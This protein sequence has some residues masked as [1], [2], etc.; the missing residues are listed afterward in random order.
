M[1]ELDLEILKADFYNTL[2][3]SATEKPEENLTA[4]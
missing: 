3:T 4:G 2:M 1:K